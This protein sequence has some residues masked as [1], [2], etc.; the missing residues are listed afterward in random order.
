MNDQKQKLFFFG[1]GNTAL[2]VAN[3]AGDRFAMFGTTRKAE[4]VAELEKAGIEAILLEQDISSDDAD[5]LRAILSCAHVLISYP[6]DQASDRRFGEL[7]DGAKSLIYISSTGVYGR[8]AGVVDETTPVDSEDESLQGRLAQERFWAERRAVVLRAPGLY[9]PTSG[10]HVRL[11]QG[12]YRLPGDG[13]NFT[14]RIHLKDLG[15]LILAAFKRPLPEGSTFLVGDLKPACQ[16]EV[17]TWL[18]ATMNLPM[19]ESVPLSDAPK[20]LKT[21]RRVN[22]AKILSELNFTLEFPTYKEGFTHCLEQIATPA[23]P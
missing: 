19:P 21:N 16:M 1:V 2:W 12:S 15:R 7:V 13:S 3:Q 18:C 17:V 5:K 4:K 11:A 23:M 6:P 22:P 10:L 14:S 8:R 20:S 9:C